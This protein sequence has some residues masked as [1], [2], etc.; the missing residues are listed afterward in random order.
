MEAFRAMISDGDIGVSSAASMLHTSRSTFQYV[1]R[2]P[3]RRLKTDEIEKKK[4]IEK[5]AGENIT[6]GY[7][8]IRALL[9]RQGVFISRKR[10]RR[11]LKEMN[12]QREAHFP[13]PRLPQTGNLVSGVPDVRWYT[14]ITYIETTDYGNCAFIEIEDSCT[15]DIRAWNFLVSCGASEAFSVVEDAVMNTFPS[16][17]TDGLCLKTDGGSQFTSTTFREGCSLLGITLEAIRKR[18]PE[19]NGMI[20]SLHGHFKNDYVFIR[21]T[22]S[23]V[24]TKLMLAAAVRH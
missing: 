3:C 1:K 6:Y 13:R 23:F 4:L 18:R 7:R 2:A 16:G 10:V 5:L 15:R 20:E 12:L 22:M 14:D 9:R 19:D 8:R 17:R 24:E 11:M 21:E